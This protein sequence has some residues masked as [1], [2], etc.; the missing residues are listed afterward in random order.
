MLQE[1]MLSFISAAVT[2]ARMYYDAY[3]MTAGAEHACSE[4]AEMPNELCYK[5]DMFAR[6]ATQSH[7]RLWS[8]EHT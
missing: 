2:T 1:I 6:R 7:H 5:Q 3:T 4:S 8:G